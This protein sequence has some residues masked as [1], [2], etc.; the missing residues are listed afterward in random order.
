M[1][2]NKKK[3]SAVIRRHYAMDRDPTEQEVRDEVA[4]LRRRGMSNLTD[5][6]QQL[7]SAIGFDD[8]FYKDDPS[9]YR[10]NPRTREIGRHV[11]NWFSADTF[12]GKRSRRSLA[13][14]TT[15]YRVRF[16][17]RG[18]VMPEGERSIAV[19]L[20]GT[21]IIVYDLDGTIKLSSGGWHTKTTLQRINALL[22]D[23]YHVTQ[24]A[25][26]WIVTTPHEKDVTFLDNMILSAEPNTRFSEKPLSNPGKFSSLLDEY[27]YQLSLESTGEELGNVEDI[28]YH[29]RLNQIEFS[30][31]VRAAEDVGEDEHSARKAWEQEFKGTRLRFLDHIP[32]AIVQVNNQGFV[33]VTYYT[34][35]RHADSA[36]EEI[37]TEYDEFM[38]GTGDDED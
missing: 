12:L 20:H 15:V 34:D 29:A 5:S 16:N 2:F 33:G 9:P 23:G 3:L 31:I 17:A 8:V 35:E 21:E 13:N 7:A 18:D 10:G 1:P 14:N 11:H 26:R 22:P 25:F 24:K 32:S 38:K 37:Q 19:K 6:Q 4:M 27:V 30:D 28:G 36:W